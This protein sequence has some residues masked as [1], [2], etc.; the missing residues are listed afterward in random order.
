MVVSANNPFTCYLGTDG[1]PIDDGL[2]N[3][4]VANQDPVANPVAIF[5]DAALSVPA[6][7]PV[8]TLAGFASNGGFAGN[9]YTA[10]DFS[11]RVA[12]RHNQQQFTAPTNG[13]RPGTPGGI[14]L[15]NNEILLAEDG[16]SIS[17]EDGSALS[18]GDS[19]GVGVVVTTAPNARWTGG[20]IPI[21][22]GEPLGS[23]TR[24]WDA[25]L[26]NVE[27]SNFNTAPTFDA[28]A[29]FDDDIVMNAEP[30]KFVGAVPDGAANQ[31]GDQ[32]FSKA[33]LNFTTAAGVLTLNSSRNI[34]G[35]PT[36]DAG[37]FVIVI[38]DNAMSSTNFR[39]HT[40]FFR[41]GAGTPLGAWWVVT[42]VSTTVIH[43]YPYT[44]A[45]GVPTAVVIFGG[46]GVASGCILDV[47]GSQ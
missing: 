25:F 12:D 19:S 21:V 31:M 18:I 6:S 16:S 46:A 2:I 35:T 14:V 37:G 27:A 23:A 26:D 10:G 5:W 39:P 42:I 22:T 43:L 47:F 15:A 34:N 40:Q 3:F 1:Q 28:G 45:A 33:S 13:F 44:V 9:I 41:A 17:M 20:L 36:I 11:I 30:V 24:L 38:L 8:R 7:Q 29:T 32:D 4:G